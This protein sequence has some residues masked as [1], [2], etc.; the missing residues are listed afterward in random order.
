MLGLVE[1]TELLPGPRV[2]VEGGL[3]IAVDV[4]GGEW[5]CLCASGSCMFARNICVCVGHAFRC[6]FLLDL[7]LCM[8]AQVCVVPECVY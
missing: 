6:V 3:G 2:M 4:D 8:W 7:D 5:M 1:Q